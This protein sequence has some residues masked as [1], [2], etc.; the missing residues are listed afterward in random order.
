MVAQDFAEPKE[1]KWLCACNAPGCV[2]T[3]CVE[4]SAE[5]CDMCQGEVHVYASVD[6]DKDIDPDHDYQVD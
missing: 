5:V 3:T 2:C 6:D 4:F 1:H